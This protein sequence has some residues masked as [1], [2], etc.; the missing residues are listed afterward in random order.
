MLKD[1]EAISDHDIEV[2]FPGDEKFK[3]A[4]ARLNNGVLN[5]G[6]LARGLIKHYLIA[7]LSVPKCVVGPAPRT[8]LKY[9]SGI[10]KEVLSPGS[11][12]YGLI[13]KEESVMVLFP[14]LYF[15]NE[16]DS[17]VLTRVVS[18]RVMRDDLST[19]G[20]KARRA[21]EEKSS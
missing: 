2:L 21:A 11:N 7:E 13:S 14:G 15:C 18:P 1:L 19:R 9:D 17:S 10:C 3:V 6:E 16:K 5:M 8:E 12:T 4:L 20:E